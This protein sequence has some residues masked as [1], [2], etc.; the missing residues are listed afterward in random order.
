MSDD[1]CLN[2]SKE[3]LERSVECPPCEGGPSAALQPLNI[4]LKSSGTR[5]PQLLDRST[6]RSTKHLESK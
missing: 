2:V 5:L 6:T 1:L 3:Y 4:C